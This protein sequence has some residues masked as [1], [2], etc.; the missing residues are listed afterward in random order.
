MPTESS[1]P[2]NKFRF[3]VQTLWKIKGKAT[4]LNDIK[5]NKKNFN[6]IFHFSASQDCIKL[7]I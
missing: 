5:I 1:C 2:E 7:G 4:K 6:G 3:I